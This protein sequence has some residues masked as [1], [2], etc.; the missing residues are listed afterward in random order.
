[1]ARDIR[2]QAWDCIADSSGDEATQGAK[3]PA[4]LVNAWQSDQRT[5]A[6]FNAQMD[7]IDLDTLYYNHAYFAKETGND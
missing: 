6:Y 5:R 2:D 7:K 1:L 4:Q 3:L